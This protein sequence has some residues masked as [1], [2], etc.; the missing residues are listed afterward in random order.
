MSLRARRR[1]DASL[2]DLPV[3]MA[4]LRERMQEELDV[5]ELAHLGHQ[6]RR[7]ALERILNRILARSD[8]LYTAGQRTKMVRQLVDEALGLGALEPLLEDGTINE[9]MINGLNSVWVERAGR[10]E[11][12]EASFSTEQQLLNVVD[13]IVSR[14]NRRVDESSPMVDA[15]LP[16]GERVNVIIKPLAL[17]GPTVTIRRFPTMFTLDDLVERGSLDTAAATLLRASVIG[18]LNIMVSGGTGSGKTTLLNALS[19]SIPGSERIVTIEDSA[20]LI[21][22]QSHVVR[23]ESRPANSENSGAITIRD[24][25]RNS[26]RMRPDRIIVGEV[27][28]AETLDM[29]QAM[30]TGHEG[31]MSTVHANS[32][33]QALSRLTT[34][35]AMS[36]VKIAGESIHDQVNSA[37]EIIVQL[38]RAADGVRRVTEICAIPSF[39]SEP[40]RVV[41]LW[42]TER[43][44]ESAAEVGER[45]RTRL[46]GG[47]HGAADSTGG[48]SATNGVGATDEKVLLR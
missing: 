27:R 3:R 15:R 44:L 36:D 32:T 41:P 48:E 2:T 47:G 26:L 17:G 13:R 35:T 33:A 30:N 6:M 37:M 1:E 28:G 9:I 23:L 19:A 10:L 11:K 31:S 22:Q 29:L 34:L 21:F 24:L 42:R 39:G 18:R 20:E 46:E 45:I 43:G 38:E 12:V 4:W 40:F 16:G 5:T 25:V 14:V 7:A 8:Y